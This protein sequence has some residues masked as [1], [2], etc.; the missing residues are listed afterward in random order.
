MLMQVG[1]YAIPQSHSIREIGF[2]K[3]QNVK[4]CQSLSKL[5]RA[6]IVKFVNRLMSPVRFLTEIPGIVLELR[7][8]IGRKPVIFKDW[9]GQRYW[10]YP[11][12]NVRYNW[13]RK[14]VTDANH[15]VQYI[16]DNVKPGWTCVDIGAN[17]GA[18]SVPLWS[19]V[20]PSGMVIS[21]EADPINID[22]IKANL[23]LNSCPED[24]VANVAIADKKGVMQL[25]V[26]P[27]CNGWQT[28]GNPSFAKNYE[29]YIID[30]PAIDFV[31]LADTYKI[32]TVDFIKIDV[33]GAEILVLDGMRSFLSE[34]KIACLVFEVNHLMLEGMNSNVRQLMSFWE[35]FDYELW[36]L[37]DDGTP[38][39]IE[40]SWP[41]NL[42]GDC[43]AFPRAPK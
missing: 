17:I 13:K 34:K 12:D 21:V 11:N 33:E 8:K 9:A 14:S 25:R 39:A 38:V 28:L 31:E 37:A 41:S 3:M 27:E 23:K 15:I 30:I 20:G 6:I 43:I 16:L 7:L 24:Y 18:V 22:K 1:N 4:F 5:C 10:Q 32:T 40:G 42:I 2:L 35:D 29:S 26:Y 36:R 19:K